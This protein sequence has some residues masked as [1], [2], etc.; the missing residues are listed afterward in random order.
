MVQNGI[1]DDQKTVVAGGEFLERE[2]S[3]LFV[4]FVS[5][6]CEQW[7]KLPGIDCHSYPFSPFLK[8]LQYCIINIVVDQKDRM[9]STA[10]KILHESLCIKHLPFEEDTSLGNWGFFF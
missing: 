3:V 6:Q 2:T 4:E 5:L 8:E 10:N 1:I 9:L 7:C